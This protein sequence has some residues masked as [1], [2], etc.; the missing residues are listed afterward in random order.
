MRR[1]SAIPDETDHLVALDRRDA[2]VG[3]RDK[4]TGDDQRRRCLLVEAGRF[5]NLE[6]DRV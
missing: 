5:G 6:F 2:P 1:Q 4:R 3:H